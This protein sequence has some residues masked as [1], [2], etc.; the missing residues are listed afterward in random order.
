MQIHALVSSSTRGNIPAGNAPSP[1]GLTSVY[2]SEH[3]SSVLED[4]HSSWSDKPF[5]S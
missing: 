3:N 2:F 5:I 4:Q 1:G